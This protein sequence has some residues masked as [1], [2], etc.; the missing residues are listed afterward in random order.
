MVVEM[1]VM[2]LLRLARKAVGVVLMD[3]KLLGVQE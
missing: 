1:V 3:R 2:V